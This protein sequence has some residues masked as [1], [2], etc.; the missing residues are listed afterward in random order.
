MRYVVG[1]AR[2]WYDFI[3]GDSSVL[4]A[5]G[6]AA[7]VIG[8]ILVHANAPHVAEVA[9]P[10]AVVATLAISILVPRR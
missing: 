10:A 6:A 5:G 2:F 8:A 4:A 9:L 3:V 1:F 7:L